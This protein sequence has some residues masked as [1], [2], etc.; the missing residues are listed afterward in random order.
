MH[1]ITFTRITGTAVRNVAMFRKAVGDAAADNVVI[2]TSKWDRVDPMVGERRQTQLAYH[3]QFFG[4]IVAAGA[5]MERYQKGESP[6][7][8]FQAIIRGY[9]YLPLQIQW[10]V[11]DKKKKI[12]KTAAG[13]LLGTDIKQSL[14]DTKNKYKEQLSQLKKQQD[15]LTRDEMKQMKTELKNIRNEKTKSLDFRSSLL[16]RRVNNK[17]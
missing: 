2:V 11:V 6:S 8:I 14:K 12:G 1:D 4:D 7:R 5:Q 3:P 10:E 17:I 15:S 16:N 13:L 9:N